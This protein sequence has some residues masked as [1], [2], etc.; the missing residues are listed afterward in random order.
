MGL[1]NWNIII[2]FR[3]QNSMR[4]G[5]TNITTFNSQQQK[6]MIRETW[7]W[8]NAAALRISE[9][10]NDRHHNMIDLK[11]KLGVGRALL[12]SNNQPVSDCYPDSRCATHSRWDRMSC[13]SD[14][15][16]NE[17]F[18]AL[19]VAVTPRM[20]QIS[21]NITLISIKQIPVTNQW[22]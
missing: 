16:R 10:R 5:H 4:N 6:S 13:T 8:L 19:P 12:K 17:I 11:Q 9:A 14:N 18:K 2:T 20:V 15:P 22:R 21:S 1:S 7:N 3:S